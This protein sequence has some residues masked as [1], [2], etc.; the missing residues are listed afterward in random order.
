MTAILVEV[1]RMLQ[2][3]QARTVATPSLSV[4]FHKLVLELALL[5]PFGEA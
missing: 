5:H 4:D 2:P 3:M 1:S